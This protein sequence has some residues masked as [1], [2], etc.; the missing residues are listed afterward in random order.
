MN[1]LKLRGKICAVKSYDWGSKFAI[2]FYADKDK[3]GKAF[4]GFIDCKAFKMKPTEREIVE[5]SGWLSYEKFS[6][7][8]KNYSRLMYVV[9]EMKP[10]KAGKMENYSEIE[11]QSFNDDEIPF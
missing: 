4:Y 9:K 10:Y 6:H 3:D 5:T 2:N 1:E 11:T 8:G 7:D